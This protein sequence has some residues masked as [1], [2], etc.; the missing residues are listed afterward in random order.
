MKT[1]RRVS[2]IAVALLVISS[3]TASAADPMQAPWL[4]GLS[5]QK[6]LEF[7]QLG[8]QVTQLFMGVMKSRHGTPDQPKAYLGS[9]KAQRAVFLKTHGCAK[10]RFEVQKDIPSELKVGLF[11]QSSI[12]PVYVRISSDT[13]PTTP[14]AD[15][16]TVGIS[17]K[18]TQVPGRKILPGEETESTQD[19]LLQNHH[20]F[21]V[22]NAVDFYRIFADAKQLE[23]ENPAKFARYRQI[24]DV[25]MTKQ[26]N[27]VFETQYWSTT[28]YKFGTQ[29]FAKYKV[30]PC[31]DAQTTPA[32]LQPD[33]NYL[34]GGMFEQMRSRGACLQFQVQLR[35]EGMPLDESTVEWGEDISPPITVAKIHLPAQDM[36]E[37]Q[38]QCEDFSFTAWH[39]LPE[40]QPE[41]SVNKLRGMVY[42][43]LSQYR[44]QVMNQ[45][46]KAEPTK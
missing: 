6:A 19:F 4:E 18:V 26:V 17:I 40:H 31:G 3:T 28:P 35:K 45:V 20:V 13:V 38:N 11:A 37:L 8:D 22:D 10:G 2:L 14:D 21:F 24:L 7:Q 9:L 36:R 44:R 12:K 15:M 41:G 25:D 27:N 16:S 23:T 39:S 29:N 32:P 34:S 1:N 46:L 33:P 43:N 5:D 30:T 42:S